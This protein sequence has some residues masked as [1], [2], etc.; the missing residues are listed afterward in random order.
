MKKGIVYELF[1]FF[2]FLIFYFWW[3]NSGVGFLEKPENTIIA[4]GRLSGLLAVFF[5][6]LQFMLIGRAVWIER[7]FG[8]DKLSHIHH[9]NGLFSLTFIILH[10]LLILL[11]YSLTAHVSLVKQFVDFFYSY[12]DVWQ[13]MVAVIVFVV[14]ICFSIYIVRRK[15][16]YETWYFIH[17]LTYVAVFLAWG[18]Q[19]Q[20]GEDFLSNQTFVLY[21]YALYI[22][23]LGNHVVFRFVMPWL[24]FFR[25]QFSVSRVVRESPHANSVYI[26]G[27]NIGNFN[28][29]PG[30]FMIFRF[31]QKSFWWQTHPFSL[32]M[33]N[34]GTEIRITPKSVGD[35]T[36]MIPLLKK[37]TPVVIDGPFGTFTQS[38]DTPSK[39]LLI[40]GGI[41]ITPI[42]SLIE[43]MAKEK[44]DVVLLYLN[45][46]NSEIV[47]RKELDDIAGRYKSVK[48]FYILTGEKQK[49]KLL[50]GRIDKEKI[51]TLVP[52]YLDREV[53]LCGP[54]AM[55][56]SLRS[57]LLG[58][59]IQDK[60]IHFEKFSL[61]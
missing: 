31:L 9:L 26:S 55:M 47:F 37:G 23:V 40:A 14:I 49:N 18:H 21:W 50:E 38:S 45:R 22:F 57:L 3:S 6:L 34:S 11:G 33:P 39:I 61:H 30:Q 20:N 2:L 15:L 60:R 13:A 24:N 27:K 35:Y 32:S 4:L 51:L 48:I 54:K 59:G 28:I 12:P 44:K 17:L 25:F 52:G 58:F 16:K 56:K 53:Y 41:G 42:R 7:L 29:K 10:P 5:V 1:A 46:T 8:L 19:L 36:S 43:E